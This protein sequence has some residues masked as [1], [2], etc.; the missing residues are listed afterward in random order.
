MKFLLDKCSIPADPSQ[1][2]RLEALLFS[3]KQESICPLPTSPSPP[4]LLN[5]H[6]VCQMA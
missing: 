1:L 5:A 6:Y 3:A 2:Q 4:L